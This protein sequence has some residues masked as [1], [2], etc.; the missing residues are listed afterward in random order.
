VQDYHWANDLAYT[1]DRK[2]THFLNLIECVE[3]QPDANGQIV[4]LHYKW[5][6]NFAITSHNVVRLANQGDRLRWK[7]ENEGFKVQKNSDLNLEHAYSENPCASKVFYLLLQLACIIFQLMEKGSLLEQVFP[8]GWSS[9][10]YLAFRL[11]EAW[12]NLSISPDD[13]LRPAEGQFQIRFNSS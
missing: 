2:H 1:D 7:I 9:A 3:K 8:N 11:L 5:L 10:K 12:R 13:L 6:T 4:S